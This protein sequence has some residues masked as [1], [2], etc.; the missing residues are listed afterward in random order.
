[1]KTRFF[2]TVLVALCCQATNA[3][4]LF[5]KTFGSAASENG[6]YISQTRDHGYILATQ[7]GYVV[8]TDSSGNKLWSEIVGS[9]Y[10]TGIIQTRD[11]GYIITGDGYYSNVYSTE[12]SYIIKTNPSGNIV[13]QQ[14]YTNNYAKYISLI[15]E[16]IDSSGYIIAGRDYNNNLLF[17]KID[18]TGNTVW[19]KT[20]EPYNHYGYSPSPCGFV[21]L[22]GDS[23]LLLLSTYR[24]GGTKEGV[25]L[26]KITKNGDLIWNKAIATSGMWPFWPFHGMSIRKTYNG[27]VMVGYLAATADF[28][29]IDTS[30]TPVGNV[31]RYTDINDDMT[32]DL[33]ESAMNNTIYLSYSTN[34]V[35]SDIVLMKTDSSG[36]IAWSTKVGGVNT[37]NSGKVIG[38]N[39]KGAAVI[40]TTRSFGAGMVDIY[41]LKTDSAGTFNCNSDTVPYHDT[42]QFATAIDTNFTVG[43]NSININQVSLNFTVSHPLDTSYDVCVCVPPKAVFSTDYPNQ[44]GWVTDS[45]T[46]ATTYIW[47]YGN[48]LIDTSLFFNPQYT[49][50]TIYTVCLKVINACGSDSVCHLLNYMTIIISEQDYDVH[51]T[52]KIYPDPFSTTAVINF[53]RM[54]NDAQIEIFDPFGQKAEMI[55]N[56]SGQTYTL[57]RGHLSNGL[58]IVRI[59]NHDKVLAI[60]KIII[61]E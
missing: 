37:E 6:Y 61:T 28:I 32:W 48:G 5:Q 39:D 44:S 55:K 36:N 43:Y 24:Y 40:G 13:W 29:E 23:S 47:N 60:K 12:I 56:V 15:N 8:K 21:Q 1:M 35:L 25:L 54:V 27:N 7:L 17:M 10:L 34:N 50:D 42:V 49:Q 58:Y 20:L 33:A 9:P 57:G 46:W 16:D 52:I 14:A 53:G 2:L 26:T 45:S 19:A 59:T 18:L 11:G 41:L 30:G 38:T 3:Q 22:S 31:K 4:T 51:S